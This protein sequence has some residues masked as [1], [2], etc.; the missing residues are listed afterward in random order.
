MTTQVPTRFSDEELS[1]LDGLIA[2]GVAPSRSET[3]RL[4][5]ERLADAHRR[6]QIGRAIAEA[7]EALPQTDEENELALA[8]AI[9]LSE[10][11]PW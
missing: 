6:E 4:A 3:I 10:A 5:V 7:Y 1:V 9:A 8:S 2:D 11:E